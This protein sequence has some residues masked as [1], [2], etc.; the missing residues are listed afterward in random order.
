[1]SLFDYCF[2]IGGLYVYSAEFE[3]VFDCRKAHLFFD[4]WNYV[5]ESEQ[6]L[7]FIKTLKT[8]LLHCLSF[9]CKNPICSRISV[10]IL[11]KPC[12]TFLGDAES[13]KQVAVGTGEYED[14]SCG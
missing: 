1:M 10:C 11:S 4:Q 9:P 8:S 5:R 7:I 6:E 2:R 12:F 14:I 13:P 3:L